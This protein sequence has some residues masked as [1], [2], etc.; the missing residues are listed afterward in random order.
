MSHKHLTPLA[1]LY[2]D[3]IRV[4]LELFKVY[5]YGMIDTSVAISDSAILGD[6]ISN[7]VIDLYKIR[8]EIKIPEIPENI[9]EFL[10]EVEIKVKTSRDIPIS[11]PA[12]ALFNSLSPRKVMRQ[13]ANKT[14]ALNHVNKSK[15]ESLNNPQLIDAFRRNESIVPKNMKNK[16]TSSAILQEYFFSVTKQKYYDLA[17]EEE[18][19]TLMDKAS[20]GRETSTMFKGFLVGLI[21]YFQPENQVN[22]EVLYIGLRIFNCYLSFLA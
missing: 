2:E 11:E 18:F 3:Y 9:T 19:E 22:D 4:T 15:Q 5:I 10:D 16:N 12:L 7:L 20:E 21:P 13:K 14:I 1:M 17:V 8:T 6:F